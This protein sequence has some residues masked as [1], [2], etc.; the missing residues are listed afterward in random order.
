MNYINQINGFWIE[1][2][3]KDLTGLDIAVYMALLK[4][5]NKLNW[6]NPFICHWD[7]VC[8]T[9]KVS[10]NAYYKSLIRLNDL[11][12]IVYNKGEKNTNVKPKIF[13]IV[14]EN[15]EGIIKEQSSNKKGIDEEQTGNLYKLLNK[16]TIKLI[17]DNSVLINQKL[18]FWILKEEESS[19]EINNL[20]IPENFKSIW[21]LWLE[22]RKAKKIKNYAGEKFEQMAIDKLIK[23][24]KGNP[25]IAK[26]IIENSITNSYTGF[27]EL[28]TSNI[29]QNGNNQQQPIAGK[30][31]FRSTLSKLV[32][33]EHGQTEFYDSKGE[34]FEDTEYTELDPG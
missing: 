27:F 24:S 9:S 5:C 34:L 11:G 19:L 29:K 18:S 30:P 8:Q 26:D 23:F 31:K 20:L 13:I 12:F 17:N 3:T 7:I 33:K 15:K 1:S 16:E 4:Y 6:L 21:N 25:E 10:K 22:Y 32:E 2:E 28:K 14:L